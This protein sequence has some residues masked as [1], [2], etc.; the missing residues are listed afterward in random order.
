[1]TE[2]EKDGSGQ[3]PIGVGRESKRQ[4]E[5]SQPSGRRKTFEQSREKRYVANGA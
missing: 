2:G 3:K 5:S 1:L 4:Q